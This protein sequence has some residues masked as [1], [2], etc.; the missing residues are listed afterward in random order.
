M[1][2]TD[3]F[4]LRFPF[5]FSFFVLTPNLFN[6]LFRLLHFDFRILSSIV[7]GLWNFNTKSKIRSEKKNIKLN[8][9]KWW[10]EA[11]SGSS[12]IN[13]VRKERKKRKWILNFWQWIYVNLWQKNV[14]LF[15][16]WPFNV[17]LCSASTDY[18]MEWKYFFAFSRRRQR[19]DMPPMS[20]MHHRSDDGSPFLRLVFIHFMIDFPFF[21]AVF[22][23][24]KKAKSTRCGCLFH[25]HAFLL[26]FFT[27]LIK[28]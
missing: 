17:V 27:F 14:L 9:S 7:F 12:N 19:S 25:S 18:L 1:K 11:F 6:H 16:G 21:S 23:D 8:Q 2:K 15:V 28:E 10:N 13:E 24:T 20:T 26:Y 3:F 5:S 4:P 22:F